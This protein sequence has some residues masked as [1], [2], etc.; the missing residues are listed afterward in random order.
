MP[1]STNTIPLESQNQ[2]ME[3]QETLEVI[4]FNPPVFEIRHFVMVSFVCLFD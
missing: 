3:T 2:I 1:T 4:P